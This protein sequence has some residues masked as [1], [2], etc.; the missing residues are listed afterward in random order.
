MDDDQDNPDQVELFFM[1]LYSKLPKPIRE[2]KEE[3]VYIMKYSDENQLGVWWSSK[4]IGNSFIKTGFGKWLLTVS[5]PWLHSFNQYLLDIFCAKYQPVGFICGFGIGV[6]LDKKTSTTAQQIIEKNESASQ[7]D[8]DLSIKKNVMPTLV[9]GIIAGLG[10][11]FLPKLFGLIGQNSTNESTSIIPSPI[12]S[13]LKSCIV[14]L[15]TSISFFQGWSC[16]LRG[17]EKMYKAESQNRCMLE[18]YQNQKGKIRS[19]LPLLPIRI[20]ER[21]VDRG[22]SIL[23]HISRVSVIWFH[24]YP[25]SKKFNKISHT[26]ALGIIALLMWI[27]FNHQEDPDSNAS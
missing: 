8:S 22:V 10:I 9:Q 5:W 24:F 23:P 20:R 4:E 27:K 19:I 17:N 14:I 16:I 25:I 1:D 11:Y 15:S 12:S 13:A 21:T 2:F 6:I 26:S 7:I 18:T 3:S